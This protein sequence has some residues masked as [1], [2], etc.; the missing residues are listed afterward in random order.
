MDG[1]K[2]AILPR[3]LPQ[4]HLAQKPKDYPKYMSRNWENFRGVNAV[5]LLEGRSGYTLDKLIE[6]AYDPFIAGFEALIPGFG[7][8]LRPE[9]D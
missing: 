2:T 3:L 6:V 4:E 5:R 8:R 9:I 7:S 1:F